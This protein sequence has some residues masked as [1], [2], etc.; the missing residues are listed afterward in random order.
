MGTFI[1]CF[2]P[3]PS[4]AA[5]DGKIEDKSA[6]K[7]QNSQTEVETNVEKQSNDNEKVKKQS[8]RERKEERRKQ[9][10]KVE[11]K[12]KHSNGLENDIKNNE[13]QSETKSKKKRKRKH[14][15]DIETEE[16]LKKR[17]QSVEGED[18]STPPPCNC[19]WDLEENLCYDQVSM[20]EPSKS[21][22]RKEPMLVKLSPCSNV[23][24][25]H[26]VMFLY[27]TFSAWS[28]WTNG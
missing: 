27:T 9:S 8:K 22:N 26:T 7:E 15:E 24:M 5:A 21:Q 16:D 25:I 2:F 3:Q 11:K 17:Q 10:Q 6:A 19:G 14:Q 13:S 20:A 1:V 4:S 12:H 23:K 18:N 28:T